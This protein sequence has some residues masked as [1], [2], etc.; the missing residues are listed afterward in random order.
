M[1]HWIRFERDRVVGFGQLNGDVIEEFS[2][3]MFGDAK[4]AG[5]S[6]SLSAVNLL[7][8]C[9]PSKIVAL[10]N[11]SRSICLKQKRDEPTTPLFFLKASNTYLPSGGVIRK[12]NTHDGPIVYEAELGIVIGQ[13]CK[14]IPE[15][16]VDR[17]V[18]GYTCV[19]DV[20]APRVVTEVSSFAQWSKAKGFDTFTPFGPIIS[21]GIEVDTLSIRAELNG[22]ERQNYSVDDYFFRPDTVVS[23]ISQSMTLYPGDI[24]SCGTGLGALPMKPGST[25]DVII[26]SIGRLENTFQA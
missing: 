19:N 21:T 4:P 7:T 3:D 5:N 10:W 12:P 2:G 25:I 26:D 13:V 23:E 24:I 11:N 15:A 20:T 6:L 14:E 9:I 22:R 18:F 1:T 16:D 17:Y 8:P